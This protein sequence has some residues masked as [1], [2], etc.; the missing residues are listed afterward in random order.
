MTFKAPNLE[1]CIKKCSKESG[2]KAFSFESQARICRL[3]NK[4]GEMVKKRGVTAGYKLAT[5]RE[6]ND[7]R[8]RHSDS[9]S[10]MRGV[11]L[12]GSDYDHFLS[13]SVSKCMDRC[14]TDSRCKAFTYHKKK[15]A[16]WLKSGVPGK[17]YQD[18]YISGI[19]NSGNGRYGAPPPRGRDDRYGGGR[20]GGSRVR[21]NDRY[22][23]DEIARGGDRYYPN[24]GRRDWGNVDSEVQSYPS[25]RG[26]GMQGYPAPPRNGSRSGNG[27]KMAIMK[28]VNLPGYDYTNFRVKKT[29]HCS[30]QCLND[31]QCQ[32]FTFNVRANTCWLKS[33]R[34]SEKYQA[35]YVSGVKVRQ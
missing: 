19:K 12:P 35:G 7:S 33:G 17:K 1:T 8:I 6:G 15:G 10:T 13:R 18:S 28:K 16:C 26:N 32:A 24:N 23:E 14:E 22:Y 31:P 27:Y 9:M 25:P 21:G 5:L 11:N 3:K 4:M 30:R 29:K 20:Y 2:C 34:P